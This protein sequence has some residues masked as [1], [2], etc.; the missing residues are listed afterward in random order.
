[1]GQRRL[2]PN[3]TITIPGSNTP[4]KTPT[5]DWYS[6]ETDIY[7][8]TNDKASAG[9]ADAARPPISTRL[10]KQRMPLPLYY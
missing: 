7:P 10:S 6:W 1:M 8:N 3:L 4:P 5:R 9:G 2:S